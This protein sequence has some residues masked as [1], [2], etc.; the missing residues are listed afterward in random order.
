MTTVQIQNLLDQDGDKAR[1]RR[2][3]PLVV[4]DQPA[5]WTIEVPPLSWSFFC[6]SFWP[7]HMSEQI[8]PTIVSGLIGFWA[9]SI[10]SVQGD[11]LTFRIWNFWMVVLYLLPLIKV[12]N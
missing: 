8:A 1:S 6:P 12:F 5:R 3:V 7:L 4:G 10:K 9:F 11:K 2:T